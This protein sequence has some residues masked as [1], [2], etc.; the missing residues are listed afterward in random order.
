M[1]ML[2][3]DTLY[4]SPNN[5]TLNYTFFCI[6]FPFCDFFVF[7]FFC[8]SLCFYFVF[9]CISNAFSLLTLWS[10]FMKP[11]VDKNW[12]RQSRQRK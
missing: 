5:L 11:G 7:V 12:C 8:I 2:Y 9:V 1:V 3:K 4:V 6:V 10:H